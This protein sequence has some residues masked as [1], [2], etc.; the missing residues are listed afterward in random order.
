MKLS[1]QRPSDTSAHA[2]H[3]SRTVRSSRRSAAHHRLGEE[4]SWCA[5]SARARGYSSAVTAKHSSPQL[6]PPLS[7]ATSAATSRRR[8]RRRVER[9]RFKMW[10]PLRSSDRE[11]HEPRWTTADSSPVWRSPTR[12]GIPRTR[13]SRFF[14][15]H[16][17]DSG[18][19]AS[20]GQVPLPPAAECGDEQERSGD[21]DAH[22]VAAKHGDLTPW[23]WG[24][25]SS[26]RQPLLGR[27]PPSGSIPVPRNGELALG[28]RAWK[29][30][31]EG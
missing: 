1:R 21:A 3:P 17:L 15:V 18:S 19:S 30:E 4:I 8:T 20:V 16:P 14:R 13:E 28:L 27:A 9:D 25:A 2:P 26:D 29:L 12:V 10:G 7:D 5:R 31:R 23:G 6:Q 24:T 22:E 11:L